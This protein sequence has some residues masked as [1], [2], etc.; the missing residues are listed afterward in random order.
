MA[1]TQVFQ[2]TFVDTAFTSLLTHDATWGFMVNTWRIS[3]NGTSAGAVPFGSTARISMLN[4]LANTQ[5]V[6]CTLVGSSLE[7]EEG[8]L[9]RFQE[10]GTTGFW[11]GIGYL[12]YI[13]SGHQLI[14]VRLDGAGSHTTLQT[15]SYTPVTG[16]VL[17][18]EAIGSSISAYVNGGL[19][20]TVVDTGFPNGRG[21]M[22]AAT[23][24]DDTVNMSIETFTAYEQSG[25][26]FDPAT[27]PRSEYPAHHLRPPEVV[28]YRR[29][30]SGI[31]I[32]TYARHRIPGTL[33]A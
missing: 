28:S 32:P 6:E 26:G 24:L 13:E 11:D 17:R 25:G 21:G 22:W 18:I 33:A 15:S 31:L 16:D 9:I 27:L 14:T 2:D 29:R 5:A 19:I 7:V 10:E 3:S 1:W 4:K 23:T 12:T 8:L 30:E 20:H